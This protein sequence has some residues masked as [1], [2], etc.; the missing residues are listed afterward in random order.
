[1]KYKNKKAYLENRQKWWDKLPQR[2]K[3][4]TTRPGSVKVR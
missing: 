2:E 1:M 4:A 3:D